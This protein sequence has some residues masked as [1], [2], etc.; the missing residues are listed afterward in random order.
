MTQGRQRDEWNHTATLLAMIA[1]INRDPKKGRAARPTDFHPMPDG[2]RK[3]PAPIKG[4]IT[5][6]KS[7]FVR[8]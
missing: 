3:A 4:N 6:L 2:K 7:V 1:N 8:Q 5:M